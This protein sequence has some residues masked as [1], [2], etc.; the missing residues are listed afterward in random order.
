M[1]INLTKEILKEQAEL[2]QTISV[3]EDAHTDGEIK[4]AMSCCLDVISETYGYA[5]YRQLSA[6]IDHDIDIK[7]RVKEY[8]EKA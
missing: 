5:S 1:H 3:R 4:L 6:A 7:T 2:L 8:Y